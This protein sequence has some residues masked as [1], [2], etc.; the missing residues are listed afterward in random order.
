MSEAANGTKGAAK[1]KAGPDAARA[2]ADLKAERKERSARMW[3][4]QLNRRQADS[5]RAQ[6]KAIKLVQRLQDFA[7]ANMLAAKP[8]PR[9]YMTDAQIR[10]ATVL[11]SKVVPDLQ[12]T[13]LTGADGDPI[14]FSQRKAAEVAAAATPAAAHSAYMELVQSDGSPTTH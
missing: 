14:E 10:A 4:P 6:I 11:L 2:L 8:N 3:S 12:R 13:E 7:L 9:H 5:V 1:P